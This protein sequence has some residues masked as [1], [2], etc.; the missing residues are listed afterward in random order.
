MKNMNQTLTQWVIKLA[1][2][3]G[4][5]VSDVM[6]KLPSLKDE[7]QT[8]YTKGRN[9]PKQMDLFRDQP[10]PQSSIQS[11]YKNWKSNQSENN[12]G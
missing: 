4:E 3:S 8:A 11:E 1:E 9:K 2:A 6:E 10:E 5:T 12:N 7:V